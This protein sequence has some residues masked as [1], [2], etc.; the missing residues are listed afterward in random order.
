MLQARANFVRDRK[1]SASKGKEIM[2]DEKQG[3]P[4]QAQVKE[5]ELDYM[6]TENSQES[7]PSELMV[8]GNEVIIID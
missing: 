2:P 1:S 8:D 4:G 7:F 5:E 6:L 3:S